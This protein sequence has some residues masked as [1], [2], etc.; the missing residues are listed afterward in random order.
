MSIDDEISDDLGVAQAL[1]A[2][3]RKAEADCV[4]RGWLHDYR[5]DGSLEITEAGKR[6]FFGYLAASETRH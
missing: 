1:A 5:G 6:K 3:M 4:R 2:D